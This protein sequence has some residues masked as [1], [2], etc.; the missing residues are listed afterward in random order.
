VT[1]RKPKLNWTPCFNQYTCTVNKVF[2]RLGKD[3]EAAEKQFKFLLRQVELENTPDPS[4]AFKQV[5]DRWLDV[6][7]EK[8]VSERYR[9]CK[10]RLQEFTDHVGERFSARDLRPRHVDGWLKGKT[11][12]P[13]SIR[14]YKGI[15]LSCLNWAAKAASRG[16]GALIAENP[17]RGQLDLPPTESWGK[18]AVWSQEMFD[19]VL[20]VASDAFCD[21]VRILAWTGARITTVAKLEVRHYNKLQS[22]WDCED[23]CRSNKM[24][25]HIR[26]LNDESRE[27]VERLNEKYP[28][29][30]IFR[31]AFGTPWAPDAPQI[32]MFNLQHKFKE[33]KVLKWQKG[34]AVSGLR[35]T[36]ATRFL[37]KYP[38]EI[39]YLK[40]LLGH[41]TYKM[42]HF[43][44][45]HLVDRDAEAFK[46]LDG[47]DP[48]KA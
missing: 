16:G 41:S 40:I 7:K 43:H 48:F 13:S 26:L 8:H 32:Y 25:K 45:N 14:L 46:R 11:L 30:P 47:F 22:R 34:I 35:H 19:Q 23:L 1:G 10:D 20:R 9:H 3:Q 44:Y 36:F 2:H 33:T 17:L 4:I 37:E 31:N 21:L 28:E 24:A 18:E 27:L 6:V 15:I 39:E 38:N 12:S 29:G 5:A 42:I